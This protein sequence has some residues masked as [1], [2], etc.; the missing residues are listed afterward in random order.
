MELGVVLYSLLCGDAPFAMPTRETTLEASLC[1]PEN[2][3]FSRR[4][5]EVRY[6]AYVYART[7]TVFIHHSPLLP[8]THTV[9]RRKKDCRDLLQRILHGDLFARASLDEVLNYM[10]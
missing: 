9:C 1:S 7:A 2:L 10:S 3:R 4:L 6:I 5:A 8:P